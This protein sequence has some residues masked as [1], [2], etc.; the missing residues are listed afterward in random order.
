MIDMGEWRKKPKK[1]KNGTRP[2]EWLM[3]FNGLQSTGCGEF[4]GGSV[5]EIEG[6][7]HWAGH[8]KAEEA[9]IKVVPMQS[10]TG[11]CGQDGKDKDIW[12][13]E[14]GLGRVSKDGQIGVEVEEDCKRLR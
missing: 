4:E 14:E 12:V 7:W 3:M 11:W 2:Q 5:A 1:P 13:V 6:H 10:W 9:M 8:G